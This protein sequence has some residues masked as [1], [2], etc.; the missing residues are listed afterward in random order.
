MNAKECGGTGHY[1]TFG[2]IRRVVRHFSWER[3][4]FCA[5]SRKMRGLWDGADCLP[6][7]STKLEGVAIYKSM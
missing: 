7:G 3:D 6:E 5:D 4:R 1:E 2:L